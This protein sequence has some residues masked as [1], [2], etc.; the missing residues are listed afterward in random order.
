MCKILKSDVVLLDYVDEKISLI[1]LYNDLNQYI[2]NV[3]SDRKSISYTSP[4]NTP[5]IY[6]SM[7]GLQ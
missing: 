1:D 5:K 2:A 3:K 6:C 4:K 7:L